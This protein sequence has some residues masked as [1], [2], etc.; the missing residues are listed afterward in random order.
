LHLWL[1]GVGA[2]RMVI[3]KRLQMRVAW[4]CFS[5]CCMCECSLVVQLAAKMLNLQVLTSVCFVVVVNL[6]KTFAQC[7]GGINCLLNNNMDWSNLRCS[8]M[9]GRTGKSR[10]IW[11]VRERSQEIVFFGK[12]SE[13][14]KL[15]PPHVRFLG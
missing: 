2:V 7:G 15:V 13:D 3:G 11:V 14:D 4:N 1:E 8:Y 6:H 12:V 10:G 9:S 5:V